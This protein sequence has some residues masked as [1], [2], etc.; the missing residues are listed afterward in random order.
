M[1]P[2]RGLTC[3]IALA[4]AL[5]ASLLVPASVS[6]AG[7]QG[8]LWRV[9]TYIHCD[10]PTCGGS[11]VLPPWIATLRNPFW[12]VTDGHRNFYHRA[13]IYAWGRHGNPRQCDATLFDQPFSGRCVVSD[14]G[15]G[16]VAD[17]CGVSRDFWVTT[18]TARFN[19]GAWQV[20]PFAP[21]PL[22]TCQYAMPGHYS[23]TDLL[24]QDYPGVVAYMNVTRTPR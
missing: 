1:H 23:E 17:G 21:Y 12:A 22:D 20:D 6:A 5:A 14:F 10:E 13:K 15:Q 11:E 3:S 18:E 7:G 4:L 24:G 8:A 16:Y 2:R 19:K 9:F